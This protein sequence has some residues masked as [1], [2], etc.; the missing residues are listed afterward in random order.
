MFYC[1]I[2]LDPTKPGKF[3]YGPYQFDYSPFYVGKGKGD[4]I[5]NHDNPRDTK[6]KKKATIVKLKKEGLEAIKIKLFE[7]LSESS[8]FEIEKST[9]KIIGRFDLCEGPL[10]NLT[11]GGDGVSGKIYTEEEKKYKS[12]KSKE[13]WILL[14]EDRERYKSYISK[15]SS[16]ISKSLKGVSYEERYGDKADKMKQ[17]RSDWTKDNFHKTGLGQ[18]N[19]EGENNPMFG[20]S[21]YNVWLEKFGKEEADIKLKEWKEKKSGKI[22]HNKSHEKIAQK[23]KEGNLIKIW[24]GYPECFGKPNICKVLKGRGKFAYG[25]IWEYVR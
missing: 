5:D 4:R 19:F 14:K 22:P 11:D 17:K 10:L 20:K 8:A 21:L 1:Y 16:S 9:I 18:M 25:F 2:L 12:K 3:Q 15:L 7:N 24:E 6:T 23:D 13:W